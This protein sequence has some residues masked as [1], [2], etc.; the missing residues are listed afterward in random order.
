MP[1]RNRIGKMRKFDHCESYPLRT[2]CLWILRLA[3]LSYHPPNQNTKLC[4]NSKARDLNHRP[5][6]ASRQD[7]DNLWILDSRE[8]SRDSHL[9]M[10]CPPNAVSLLTRLSVNVNVCQ[11]KGPD[12][13]S[14]LDSHEPS[15]T[16]IWV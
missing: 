9:D 6:L 7:P 16:L 13:I 10:T 4:P 12:S 3:L 2:V 14:I 11:H 5:N 1:T 15:M 8:P